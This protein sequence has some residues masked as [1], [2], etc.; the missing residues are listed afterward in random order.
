VVCVETRV[1]ASWIADECLKESCEFKMSGEKYIALILLLPVLGGVAGMAVRRWAA[2]PVMAG[3][4]VGLVLTYLKWEAGVLELVRFTWF[5]GFEMGWHLDGL[6]LT[7]VA[8]V[9]SISLLVLV[10]STHY[11]SIDEQP[12]YFAKLGFFISSMLGLLVADHFILLFIFWELVSV[13]SYLLI[14]FWY[15]KEEAAVSSAW[16]FMTNRVADTAL[17][18][19]LISLGLL[20]GFFISELT[21]TVTQA[22]GFFLLIGAMGK[23]AQFPFSAWLP[24]AMTGPTPVSALIHAATM[25][26]AGIYLLMRLNV[27]LP[28][29]VLVATVIVGVLTAL[30]GAVSAMSQHNIKRI[31]AYSTISQLGFMMVGVGMGQE[32]GSAVAFFHLW[33][34]A[35]YKAGLFLGAGVI[36]HWLHTED[37]R[38]MGGIRFSKPWLFMAMLMC[39]LSLMSFPL[40]SGFL[41]KD[42]I[43]HVAVEWSQQWVVRGYN[44]GYLVTGFLFF[45]SFLTAYY[46]GRLMF[47]VFWNQ[48]RSEYPAVQHNPWLFAPVAVLALLSAWVFHAWDFTSSTGWIQQAV[49]FSFELPHYESVLLFSLLMGAGGTVLSY[50]I[51]H[52]STKLMQGYATAGLPSTMVGMFSFNGW[53]LDGLYQKISE[54]F[55]WLAGAAH[56]VDVKIIDGIIHAIVVG[57]VVLAKGVKLIDKYVVDGLVHFVVALARFGGWM[58]SGV[59]TARVHGTIAWLLAGLLFLLLILFFL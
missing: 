32:V 6:S 51:F 15:Q 57:G 52:P 30:M 58:F 21:G 10:Y 47:S 33:T 11:I 20:H 29:A 56:W 17:L 40:F 22:I 27:V 53:Y 44:Q 42:G 3:A 23:S 35:F 55:I 1:I 49:G 54:V 18:I 43:L 24:R 9:Q 46:G 48:P 5:T 28:Q 34:H 25:V 2:W 12:R 50:S 37:I 14:G 31:L 26:T 36:I 59:Q 45:I 4:M 8:L 19:G 39:A 41:S 7:L 38:Q 13:S 16:A